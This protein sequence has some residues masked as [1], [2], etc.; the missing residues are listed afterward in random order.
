MRR[1]L[2][3]LALLLPSCASVG[4]QNS[5]QNECVAQCEN[6]YSACIF[7]CERTQKIGTTLTSCVEQCKEIWGECHRSCTGEEK[8]KGQ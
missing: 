3:I 8:S 1:F 7:E 2:I 4:P 6:T 5:S